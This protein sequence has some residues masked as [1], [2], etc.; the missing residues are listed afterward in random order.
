MRPG[1]RTLLAGGAATAMLAALGW[2]A[3]SPGARRQAVLRVVRDEFGSAIADQPG[4]GE[5]AEAFAAKHLDR[6]GR[7]A[8]ARY[9]LF[10]ATPASLLD[11][12]EKDE[13]FRDWVISSFIRS[14]TAVRAWESGAELQFFTLGSVRN[15]PCTN[16]LSAAWL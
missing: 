2:A 6:P 15:A 11:R 16:P 14:T 9:G 12:T 4:A 5:F 1:R 7:L 10:A 13:N 3:T 8:G